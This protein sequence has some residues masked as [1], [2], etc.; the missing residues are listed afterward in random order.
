MGASKAWRGICLFAVKTFGNLAGWSL[1]SMLSSQAR[2]V[3][4]NTITL[5]GI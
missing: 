4:S 2:H 1:W 5:K 3:D